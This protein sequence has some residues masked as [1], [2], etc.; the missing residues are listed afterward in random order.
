[1]KTE[2]TQLPSQIQILKSV[3]IYSAGNIL[4]LYYGGTHE[5]MYKYPG[6]IFGISASRA[7]VALA[8]GEATSKID[9]LPRT[10]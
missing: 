3:E 4:S 7:R 2:S 8:C 1:M 5:A 9:T 6:A 10:I